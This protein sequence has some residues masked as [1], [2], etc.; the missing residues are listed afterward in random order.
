LR[1]IPSD[2][3]VAE[4]CCQLFKALGFKW[5]SV[6]HADDEYGSGYKDAVSDSCRDLASPIETR[7]VSF[8]VGNEQ[9]IREAVETLESFE[10][11]IVIAIAY[12]SDVGTAVAHAAKLGMQHGWFDM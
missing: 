5:V 4:T 6:L 2:A 12:D 1:T 11:N 8:R 10:N 9:S 7:A 3:T